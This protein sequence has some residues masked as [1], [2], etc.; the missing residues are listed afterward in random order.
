MRKCSNCGNELN[1]EVQFC[2]YCGSKQE[3]REN[4]KDSVEVRF[5]IGCGRRWKEDDQF[6]PVCGKKRA[7]DP[8]AE[9]AT[10]EYTE[11]AP[12]KIRKPASSAANPIS[13]ILGDKVLNSNLLK[14]LGIIF[15]VVYAYNSLSHLGYLASDMGSFKIHADVLTEI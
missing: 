5:C 11:K 4:Y 13:D 7:E 8:L 12:A 3:N 2:P 10:E 15:C 9:A 14:I 1:E 6:C